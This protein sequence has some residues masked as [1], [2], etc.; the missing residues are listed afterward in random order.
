MDDQLKSSFAELLGRQPTEAEQKRL[1]QVKNALNIHDN[2]AIW[3]ILMAFEHYN[4][5]Y[6]QYPQRIETMLEAQKSAYDALYEQYPKRVARD[7]EQ[8]VKRQ[9]T[10]LK[11]M[12]ITE[13]KKAHAELS[14]AVVEA[15]KAIAADQ[16]RA[17]LM[18]SLGWSI[19]AFTLFGALCVFVGYVLGSG[20]VPYWAASSQEHANLASL[21]AASLART[22]AGWI[23]AGGASLT[24]CGALWSQRDK[25]FSQ[26]KTTQQW[27]L[28]AASA[29]LLLVAAVSILLIFV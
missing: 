28:I 10:T 11:T 27:I 4:M 18:L 13:T 5:L 7:L 14:S 29:V 24:A 23:I 19:F 12:A 16:T 15:S 9:Q 3:L 1:F 20:K 17:A 25:I 21:I 26:Q 8:I 22:P 6:E 2:D